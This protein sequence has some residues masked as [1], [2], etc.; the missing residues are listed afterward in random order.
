MQ[1]HKHSEKY[2][3]KYIKNNTH[4]RELER[5]ADKHRFLC[6]PLFS[7]EK[8]INLPV[9]TG[10][11]THSQSVSLWSLFALTVSHTTTHWIKLNEKASKLNSQHT[12]THTLFVRLCSSLSLFLPLDLG[13]HIQKKQQQFKNKLITQ[14]AARENERESEERVRVESN[15]TGCAFNF[16]NYL[17]KCLYFSACCCCCCCC[18]CSF[19]WA[20]KPPS[21]LLHRI[22]LC[23]WNVYTVLFK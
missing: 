20:L 5:Q 8:L 7:F 21:P 3:E 14:I 23:V 15:S 11:S 10:Q 4:K 6:H 17:I 9:H 16:V 13:A 18:C 19:H 12:H 1:T 2:T 22:S